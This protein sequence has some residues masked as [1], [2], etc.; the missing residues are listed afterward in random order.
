MVEGSYSVIAFTNSD[1][2]VS[3]N[4]RIK[5][6]FIKSGTLHWNGKFYCGNKRVETG[7]WLYADSTIM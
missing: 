2:T 6:H 1:N 5:E 3:D 7:P 4:A